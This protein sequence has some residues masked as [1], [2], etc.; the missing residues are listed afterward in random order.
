M[1]LRSQTDALHLTERIQRRR[2][3]GVIVEHDV[4][5]GHVLHGV[6]ITYGQGSADVLA[7]AARFTARHA[8]D[9]ADRRTL[10]EALGLTVSDKAAAWVRRNVWPEW[11]RAAFDNADSLLGAGFSLHMC[12]CELGVCVSCGRDEH[13]QCVT[14]QHSWTPLG[15]DMAVYGWSEGTQPEDGRAVAKVSL[16]GYACRWVCPC[17]CEQPRREDEAANRSGAST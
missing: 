14:S 5:A 17:E 3:P 8:L 10:L 4:T 2:D 13:D 1:T 11:M 9:D 16:V 7:R 12:L 6:G 15:S